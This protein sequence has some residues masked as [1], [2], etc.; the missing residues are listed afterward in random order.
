MMAADHSVTVGDETFNI[1]E[2]PKSNSALVKENEDLVMA[3]VDLDSLVTDLSMVGEFTRIAYNGVAGYTDLQIK[4]R[5]IGVRVSD[6]CDTSAITVGKFKKTSRTILTNLQTTYQFLIDGMEDMAI[7][8]LKSTAT[9]AQGM[10]DCADQ[11]AK[12]FREEAK[13]VEGALEDTCRTKDSEEKRKKALEEEEKI[14][15]VERDKAARESDAIEQDLTFHDKQYARADARQTA[16]EADNSFF[17]SIVNIFT[18]RMDERVRAARQDKERHLQEMSK[19]QQIRKKVLQDYAEFSKRMENCRHEGDLTEAAIDSLHK[20]IGGLKSLSNVM[21]KISTFWAKLESECK[22][23]GEQR[24]TET[25]EAAKKQP[26]E[27]RTAIWGSTGFKKTAIVYYARWVALG[28]ICGTYY[29]RIKVT[30]NELYENLEEN[31]TMEEARQNI[32][33]LAAAF[34]KKV[35]KEQKAIAEKETQGQCKSKILYSSCS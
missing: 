16:Y 23:L 8:T 31:L 34:S 2:I 11:L 12:A 18:G 27:E 30:Q 21:R 15:E 10:A 25:I 4:I 28:N 24:I 9:V 5:R 22:E 6:L 35:E 14:Y 17:A 19:L 32:Q 26:K 33:Q 1:L 13:Q 7:I 29:E 20:A 3:G